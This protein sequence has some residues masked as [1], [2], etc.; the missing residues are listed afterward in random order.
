MPPTTIGAFDIA[1]DI[2]WLADFTC[3]FSR[4]TNRCTGRRIS[5]LGPE[6]TKRSKKILTFATIV[7]WSLVST[8]LLRH[9]RRPSHWR[10]VTRCII[11]FLR[12]GV[13]PRLGVMPL[14]MLPFGR[15]LPLRSLTG[16]PYYWLYVYSSRLHSFVWRQ[17]ALFPEWRPYGPFGT[18]RAFPAAS[19]SFG[20]MTRT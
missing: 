5:S 15:Y 14:L 8:W 19:A 11:F 6:N 1:I 12:M 20:N 2:N 7:M 17:I 18:P 10:Q 3:M 13:L 4:F 9:K 16:Y